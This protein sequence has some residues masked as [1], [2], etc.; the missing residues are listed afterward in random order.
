MSR[1]GR[2]NIT[3]PS[4]ALTS[5]LREHGITARHSY[6]GRADQAPPAEPTPAGDEE[7]PADEEENASASQTPARN[8]SGYASDNLDESAEEASPPKKKR[9]LTKAAEAKLKA[10]EKAALDKKG[11]SSGSGKRKKLE[12]EEDDEDDDPYKAKSKGM[13]SE[14]VGKVAPIGTFQNCAQCGKKFTVTKYTLSNESGMLCHAC[15]KASGADPFKK[16]A[17]RKRKDP[18]EKRT[19]KNFEEVD[20]VKPLT[21]LCINIIGKY[22][23]QVEELGDI[24]TVNMDRICKIVSKTR[25]LTE[26]NVRLFYDASNTSLVIYDATNLQGPAY[27]TLAYFNPNLER[28]TLHLCG[29]METPTIEHWSTSLP[30]LKRL[31]LIAPF[32]V[33]DD[34]WLKF[35]RSRGPHLTGFLI[36]NVPRFTRE[37]LDA[38]I[39]HAPQL[40]ELR[41]SDIIKFE[42]SWLEPLAQLTNLTSLDISTDRSGRVILSSAAVVELLKSLGRNLALLDLSGHEDLE[43]AVL[44]DGIA[45]NCKSLTDLSLSLLPLITDEGIAAM[46]KQLPSTN[47]L[48]RLDMSRCHGAASLALAALLEHSGHTLV[49]L[50]I[51]SWKEVDEDALKLIAAKAPNLSTLDVGWCRNVNDIVIGSLI[52]A[53]QTGTTALKR[54]NCFGCNRITN[55]CP[56]RI[57]VSMHGVESDVRLQRL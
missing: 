6:F 46:F 54:I 41:L 57:G 7:Q 48:V 13:M 42:D 45:A 52:K 9:K 53:D 12:D 1:R 18:A 22:I 17:P 27:E 35:I 44:T 5:F 11:E 26:H 14:A 30:N 51:N 49:S 25:S 31:E 2:N 28:L 24:G 43:D 36:T 40:Q 37:C 34:A 55:N 50:D 20:T 39:E 15:A 33:R 21:S 47:Q 8:N 23:D 3:G 29:R 10:K 38:L 16:P 32:L 56:K 19:V 4:S